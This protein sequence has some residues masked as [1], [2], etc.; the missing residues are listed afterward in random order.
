MATAQPIASTA[1]VA[2]RHGGPEVLKLE[3]WEVAAPGPDEVRL[4]VG[5][6]GSEATAK[7]AIAWWK[8]TAERLR[9]LVDSLSIWKGVSSQCAIP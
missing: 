8:T 2:A 9:T 7:P 4:R 1:V 3:P 6:A 5:T